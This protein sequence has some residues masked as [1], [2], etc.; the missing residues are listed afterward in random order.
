[1]VCTDLLLWQKVECF[2]SPYNVK[3]WNI[4]FSKVHMRFLQLQFHHMQTI[5]NCAFLRKI[6]TSCFFF[7]PYICITYLAMH[8][9]MQQLNRENIELCR[10]SRERNILYIYKPA[11]R[12]T[13]SVGITWERKKNSIP[14]QIRCVGRAINFS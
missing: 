9:K 8:L 10:K 12:Y 1:M 2:L 13:T 5:E 11:F 6:K 4:I 14:G 3:K 7:V